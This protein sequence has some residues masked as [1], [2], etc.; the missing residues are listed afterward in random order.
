MRI[1][2]STAGVA[3]IHIS[4]DNDTARTF[5]M[6]CL[7]LE[8]GLFHNTLHVITLLLRLHRCRRSIPL[9]Y[10]RA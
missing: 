8:R 1:Y 4:L 6:P 10:M 2:Q 5:E 3:Y 7:L 9:L